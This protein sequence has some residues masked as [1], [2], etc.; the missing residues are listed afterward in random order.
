VKTWSSFAPWLSE[1][2]CPKIHYNIIN[3]NVT[4]E[5]NI[6]W[7]SYE[8]IWNILVQNKHCST[9]IGKGF[10]VVLVLSLFMK[11]I[12]YIWTHTA[13]LT[14]TIK[15]SKMVHLKTFIRTK[16][17]KCNNFLYLLNGGF[18]CQFAYLQNQMSEPLKEWTECDW[19]NQISCASWSIRR[20]NTILT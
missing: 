15:C 13:I 7:W 14:Q 5:S 20:S 19:G 17:T 12:K 10:V 18:C 2:P 4:Y 8:Q 11:Y 16:N 3:L 9:Y 1:T 6:N